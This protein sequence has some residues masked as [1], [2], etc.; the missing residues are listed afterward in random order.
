MGDRRVFLTISRL[1]GFM[2]HRRFANYIHKHSA[3]TEAVFLSFEE[4]ERI[5]DANRDLFLAAASYVAASNLNT[6]KSLDTSL[7]AER[8]YLDSIL[9]YN[10]AERSRSLHKVATIE[11]LKAE[12]ARRSDELAEDVR[13][14]KAK[15]MNKES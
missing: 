9:P 13:R 3:L 5:A 14:F 12:Y 10:N 6:R 2:D 15:Y 7:R 1:S 11:E 4:N 8:R